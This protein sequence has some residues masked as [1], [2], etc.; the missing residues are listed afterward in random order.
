MDKIRFLIICG[1]RLLCYH[2]VFFLIPLIMQ[3]WFFL[4]L[5]SLLF[6]YAVIFGLCPTSTSFCVVQDFQ[7]ILILFSEI[8]IWTNKLS[9]KSFIYP[10][11]INS[12]L[13]VYLSTVHLKRNCRYCNIVQEVMHTKDRV[14]E[15][16]IGFQTK[17]LSCNTIK[18]MTNGL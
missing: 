11:V 14:K 12:P 6:T 9:Q 8:W 4:Q 7:I 16:K 10:K 13:N 5:L 2:H 18:H 17:S 15:S 3:S 1:F